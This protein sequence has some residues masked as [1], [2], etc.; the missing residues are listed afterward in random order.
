M[1]IAEG[2]AASTSDWLGKYRGGQR[3]GERQSRRCAEGTNITK[4]VS[5]MVEKVGQG[6]K[7]KKRKVCAAADFST[8]K[9]RMDDFKAMKRAK[10]TE[11]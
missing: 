1:R 7:K 8:G 4:N 9:E 10:D 5:Q 6:T 3:D 2:F 11:R